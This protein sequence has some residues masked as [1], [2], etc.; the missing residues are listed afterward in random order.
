MGEGGHIS[1][2]LSVMEEAEEVEETLLWTLEERERYEV[3]NEE[4]GL[5]QRDGIVRLVLR[6]E[7]FGRWRRR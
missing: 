3:E 1:S 6:S 7:R 4:V 2:G 5:W